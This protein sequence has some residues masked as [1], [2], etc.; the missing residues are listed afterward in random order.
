MKGDIVQW[1]V[2]LQHVRAHFP[3]WLVFVKA[4]HAH[5]LRHLCVRTFQPGERA[6][7]VDKDCKVH[8]PDACVPYPD[9]PSTKVVFA[10][11]Q[12][13]RLDYDPSLGRYSVF[14]DG[15][16]KNWARNE[17]PHA[18]V[19]F[20]YRGESHPQKKDIAPWQVEE[21]IKTVRSRG[22][23]PA[24]LDW[25]K[26]HKGQWGLSPPDTGCLAALIERCEAFVGI[27]SGPSKIASAFDTP[28]LVC[29]T[30]HSPARYHDPAPNTTHL[31]PEG[32]EKMPPC[33][34]EGVA[35]YF[36]EHYLFRTYK[37]TLDMVEKAQE[38][39]SEVLTKRW[40]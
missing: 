8:L 32:W 36:R 7:D 19:V 18:D 25:R 34:E 40:P 4:R 14:V 10:L 1:S 11:R 33:N 27:D 39:L 9:R 35:D 15:M 2:V 38:W 22:R 37:N 16:E 31:V 24:V 23:F 30:G 13:F 6:P 21:M 28:A 3:D 17:A 12:L 20:H 26:Q 5:L 29:W